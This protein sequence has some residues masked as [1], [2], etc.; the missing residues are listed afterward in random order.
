M[1]AML[2]TKHQKNAICLDAGI[3]STIL[4]PGQTPW[5]MMRVST[6]RNLL[7]NRRAD[8]NAL[9]LNLRRASAVSRYRPQTRHYVAAGRPADCGADDAHLGVLA[10]Y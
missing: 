7:I 10:E 2:A 4:P 8:F 3:T 5:I 6:R 9:K 1:L